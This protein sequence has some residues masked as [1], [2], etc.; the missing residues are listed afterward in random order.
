MKSYVAGLGLAGFPG[1]LIADGAGEAELRDQRRAPPKDKSCRRS[2]RR[3]TTRRKISLAQDFLA[4]YPKHEAAGWVAAQLESGAAGDKNN[5]KVLTVADA[6][7]ANGPDMDAAY[8]A[9]KAAVAKEDLGGSEEM[10]GAHVGSRAQDHRFHQSAPDDDAKHEHGVRQGSGRVFRIR[11][12][13]VALKAAA[14]GR[15]GSGGYADQAESQEPISARR[16]HQLFR[17]VE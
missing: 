5:D 12:Y 4:K 1:C 7:Y 6:A 9:L 17:G 13:V 3:P 10:V 11:L 16:R 15:S 14:Q 8:Y 2:V